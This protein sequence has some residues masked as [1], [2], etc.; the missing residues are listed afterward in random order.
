MGRPQIVE[1][2]SKPFSGSRQPFWAMRDKAT[3]V[4]VAD[5][6]INVRTSTLR[7]PLRNPFAGRLQEGDFV[8]QKGLQISL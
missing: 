5:G 1:H 3:V 8:K 7:A 2:Y 6:S 4:R